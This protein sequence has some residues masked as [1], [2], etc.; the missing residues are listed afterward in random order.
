MP[1]DKVARRAADLRRKWLLERALKSEK[2]VR[3][4]DVES[5]YVSV[6]VTDP[7]Y[8]ERRK[9]GLTLFQR[10]SK[11][12]VHEVKKHRE[13]FSRYGY[14]LP[15]LKFDR[16]VL[17]SSRRRFTDRL[18]RLVDAETEWPVR[19]FLRLVLE[20]VVPSTERYL[21]PRERVTV[22]VGFGS[23]MYLLVGE[24]LKLL[25]DDDF[26]VPDICT[27]N[28][29][30]AVQLYFAAPRRFASGDAKLYLVTGDTTAT[31]DGELWGGELD[32]NTGGIKPLTNELTIDTA[33]ISYE[34]MDRTGKLYTLADPSLA[35]ITNLAVKKAASQVV[36]VGDHTRCRG[37]SGNPL[38]LQKAMESRERPVF[39]VT[40][41]ELPDGYRKPSAITEH[42]IRQPVTDRDGLGQPAI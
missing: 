24:F 21:V 33:V 10:D 11:T 39:L 19:G 6:G 7:G 27:T 42:I 18:T 4:G 35:R 22:F 3:F 38:D 37:A 26:V 25:A 36:V 9:S 34:S 31:A 17:F 40:N 41:R 30:A 29:E 16:G 13:A 14:V 12:L 23:T 28:F 8:S 1:A 5:L 2:G 20:Y 32:Y 15:D